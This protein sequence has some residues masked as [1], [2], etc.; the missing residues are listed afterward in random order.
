MPKLFNT[1]ILVILLAGF[2]FF[3][4]GWL[5]YDPL[6]GE[7]WME[8]TGVTAESAEATMGRAMIIGFILSLLQAAG[9]AAMMYGNSAGGVVNGLKAGGFAWLLFGAPVSAYSWNYEGTPLMLLEINLGYML[10]GYLLMGA[11]IGAMKKE[12]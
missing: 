9:V 8:L 6:F 11:V 1:N 3:M 12:D 7:K 10:I 4:L 5:W 2:L